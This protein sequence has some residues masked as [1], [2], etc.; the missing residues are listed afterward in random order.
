MLAFG[1]IAIQRYDEQPC[2]AL[3][4]RRVELRVGGARRVGAVLVVVLLANATHITD[5][6]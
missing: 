6:R 2:V 4:V 5:R 3:H 1:G